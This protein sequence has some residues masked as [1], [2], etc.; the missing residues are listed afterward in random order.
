MDALTVLRNANNTFD[1][2]NA[3]SNSIKIN[4]AGIYRITFTVTPTFMGSQS[5]PEFA[6]FR[7]DKN[8]VELFMC[9]VPKFD[10]AQPVIYLLE[11]ANP[12]DIFSVSIFSVP[13]MTNVS[14]YVPRL[15][16]EE[17]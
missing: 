17:V 10:R 14:I 13:D 8:G 5:S 4:K 1:T 2:V 15:T 12:G 6:T 3:P 9:G 16:I 7:I 11:S